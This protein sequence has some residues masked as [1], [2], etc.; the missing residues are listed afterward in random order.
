MTISLTQFSLDHQIEMSS[1]GTVYQPLERSSDDSQDEVFLQHYT[2]NSARQSRW[3]RVALMLCVTVLIISNAFWM[4]LRSHQS[5]AQGRF[6]TSRTAL[7]APMTDFI[8]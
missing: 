6:P 7:A 8:V 2:P 5:F 3:E 1:K 4:N